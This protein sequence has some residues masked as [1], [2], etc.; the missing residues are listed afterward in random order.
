MLD[1]LARYQVVVKLLAD[2]RP[3]SVL[4]VGSGSLG[5]GEFFRGSFVGVDV[6]FDGPRSGGLRPV[7]ASALS[8]PFRSRSF[9]LG[10]CLD[11]L[12]HLEPA[13][14]L[15]AVAEAARV[16]RRHLLIGFPSGPVAQRVD[17]ELARW[18]EEKQ[19]TRPPWLEEHLRHPYPDPAEVIRAAAEMEPLASRGNENAHLHLRIMKWEL[20]PSRWVSGSAFILR[21][22]FRPIAALAARWIHFP[23]YYRHI[24]LLTRSSRHDHDRNA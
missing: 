7:R 23:P 1:R 10:L 11:V 14:R 13:V 4:E 3:S 15:E 2:L 20:H 19:V 18:L 9:D 8:L 17:A 22:G 5:L 12:E 6:A 21:Y 16:V 24:L